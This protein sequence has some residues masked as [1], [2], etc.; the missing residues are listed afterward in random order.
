VH[1]TSG[2]SPA[3]HYGC[4][5]SKAEVRKHCS[6]VIARQQLLLLLVLGRQ[7]PVGCIEA[8]RRSRAQ[9]Q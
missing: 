3:T 1:N 8:K 6:N 4:V 9:V 7:A 5:N 2:L